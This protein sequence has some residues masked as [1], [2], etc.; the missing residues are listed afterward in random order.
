MPSLDMD[1][2]SLSQPPPFY[3][4]V[5]TSEADI[6]RWINYT[7]LVPLCA[8]GNVGQ[9]ACDLIIST[10]LSNGLCKLAGRIYS[11]ALMP[12]AGP[13]AYDHNS[14][15]DQPSTATEVYEC[16]SKKLVIMQQRTSYFRELKHLY[17]REFVQW[18]QDCKFAK[19]IVLTSSFAQCNPDTAHLGQE[20]SSPYYIVTGESSED[21]SRL[22]ESLHLRQ[23]PDEKTNTALRNGLTYLPGSG[24]TRMLI[25]SFRNYS[26]AATFLIQFCSEG[27]NIQD[28]YIVANAVDKL[29]LICDAHS[30]HQLLSSDNGWVEPSS[31]QERS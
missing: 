21:L 24:L 12:V 11:P 27:E 20:S 9:L 23:V 31:W 18:V 26:I 13:N 8:V 3:N 10:L 19:V 16:P 14:D 4:S 22:L 7:L 29:P 2:S 30:K 17:I 28:A 5:S 25:E 15:N 1:L 6:K